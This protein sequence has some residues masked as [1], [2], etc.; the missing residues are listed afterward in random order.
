MTSNDKPAYVQEPLFEDSAV[1][2][3]GLPLPWPAATE[4]SVVQ[5]VELERLR[6][7]LPLDDPARH[8]MDTVA[9]RRFAALATRYKAAA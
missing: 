8:A 5:A 2:G 6:Q 7:S 1:T 3:S 4:E 9:D